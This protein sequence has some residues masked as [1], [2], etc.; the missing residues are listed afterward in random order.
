MCY[1]NV[2]KQREKR[3][4]AKYK[5]MNETKKGRRHILYYKNVIDKKSEEEIVYAIIM[6]RR[7]GKEGGL[8]SIKMR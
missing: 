6:W 2:T 1:K 7:D 3:G 5:T 4:N 8:W